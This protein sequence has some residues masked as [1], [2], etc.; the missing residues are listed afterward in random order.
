MESAPGISFLPIDEQRLFAHEFQKDVEFIEFLILMISKSCAT[1]SVDI[2]WV[3]GHDSLR[4]VIGTIQAAKAPCSRY[5]RWD[6]ADPSQRF[7][8]VVSADGQRAAESCGVCENAAEKRVGESG[9]A[10]VYRCHAGLTDIAVPVLADG[11][12]IATLYSGQV[13]TEPPSQA[14]FE[15]VLRDVQRL[16][17]VDIKE[18]EKAYWQVPVVSEAD[19]ENT[20][21]ILELFADFLARLWK[22]LGDTVKAERGKLRARQLAAKEFAYLILQ[23]ELEDAGRLFLLMKQLGFV[24]PPNRVLVVKLQG[25]NEFD[26]PSASFDVM[27]TGALHAVEELAERTKQMAVAYLSSR[28]ICVFLRDITQGPSTGLRARSLAGKILEEIPS[29]SNVRA[30]VGIGG[31]KSGWQHLPESYHE[32][33][34]ALAASDDPIAICGDGRLPPSEL[35]TQIE[36]AC[37]HL[38]EHRIQEARMALRSLP[39]QANRRLGN[40]ALPD[41][42]NFF[43]SALESLCLTALKAGCDS[44]SIARARADSQKELVRA[45]TVFD[46]QRAFLEASDIIAEEFRGL[47]GG[48][49]EKVIARVQQML[50]RRLRVG[51]SADTFSLSSAAKAL[52]IST[53]HLSR[54]FRRMTGMTFREYV[55]SQRVEHARRLLLDPLNNVSSV[56]ESCGFSTPAYFARVFRK[57]AGCSPTEYASNPRHHLGHSRVAAYACDAG[58]VRNAEH[59]LAR[60]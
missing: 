48:K 3:D 34:L 54:T 1:G 36:T 40:G 37:H 4:Q 15:R 38:Q 41:H 44:E 55:M 8:N 10:Q 7:C 57:F 21:G 30:R 51:R 9:R 31:L 12:H 2:T 20:V 22:R 19:I 32:G 25:A 45:A 17:Y 49:H 29:H 26:P 13:L 27:F 16:S 35:T 5:L 53:G 11:R 60:V 56:S 24:Q 33:C 52:S 18:L 46:V 23:P 6:R 59:A 58:K 39:L 43:S 14:G 28:G 50:D 47:L 42:R